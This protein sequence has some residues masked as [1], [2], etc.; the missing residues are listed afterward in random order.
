[1]AARCNVRSL[2]VIVHINKI[3]V[4]IP[5]YFCILC[6]F[7]T[8]YFLTSLDMCST[9]DVCIRYK[10]SIVSKYKHICQKKLQKNYRCCIAVYKCLTF[11]MILTFEIKCVS[12]LLRVFIELS[13]I[14]A[15]VIVNI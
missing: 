14:F 7:P 2:F 8:Q 13:Y 10:V 6:S 1:M 9:Q 11:E 12:N 3:H 4:Y 5:I 15:S